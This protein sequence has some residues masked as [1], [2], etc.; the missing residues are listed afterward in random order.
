MHATL[1]ALR[2]AYLARDVDAMVALF[3]EDA[4]L[5]AAPGDFVGREE[6]RRF[7]AWDAELSPEAS[8]ED[9]GIGVRPAGAD[10][11]VWERIIDLAYEGAPYREEVVTI[12]EFD[13]S[14][15]IHRYRSYYDKLAVVQQVA[16]G[17][18]GA[19][20]FVTRGVVDVLVAAANMGVR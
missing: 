5:A 14:G 18:P 11:V 12:V 8:V 6:I 3:A 1:E 10:A 4:E 7:L 19:G 16:A 9:V 13:Q 2:A 20:G 17:L 15:L